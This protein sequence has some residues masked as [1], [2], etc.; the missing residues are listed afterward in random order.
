[1]W[2]ERIKTEMLFKLSNLALTLGYL[3]PAFNNSAQ[4]SNPGHTDG[5][6]VFSPLSHLLPAPSPPINIQFTTLIKRKNWAELVFTTTYGIVTGDALVSY[7]PICFPS[8]PSNRL[9]EVLAKLTT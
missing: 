9:P 7:W 4:D 1:M 2:T 5:K 3:N 6:R 8:V